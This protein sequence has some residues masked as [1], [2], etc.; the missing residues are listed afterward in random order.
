MNHRPHPGPLPQERENSLPAL[1]VAKVSG[2]LFAFRFDKPKR[3]DKQFE[4]RRIRS[5]QRLFP[6]LGGEG[7]GEGEREHKSFLCLP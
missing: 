7:Q 4:F 5:G 6:L 3:G 1:T 2:G